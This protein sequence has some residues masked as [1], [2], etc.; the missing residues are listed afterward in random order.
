MEH[1][2]NEVLD[3]K[4]NVIM[5]HMENVKGDVSEIK[6]QTTKTNGRVNALEDWQLTLMTQF[7]TWKKLTIPILIAIGF[8]ADKIADFVINIITR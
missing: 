4:I 8:F 5:A 7:S 1:V 3:G 6:E 2:T